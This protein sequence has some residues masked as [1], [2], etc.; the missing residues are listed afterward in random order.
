MVGTLV[1]GSAATRAGAGIAHAVAATLAGALTGLAVGSVGGLLVL[2]GPDRLLLLAL[3]TTCYGAMELGLVRLP[4]PRSGRQVPAAWRYRYPPVVTAA[5]YGALLGPG[6]GTRVAN[7]GYVVVLAGAAL[8]GD[9]ATGAAVLGTYGAARGLSAVILANAGTEGSLG[10]V[11]W[12]LDRG[13]LWRALSTTLTFAVLGA[14]VAAA[15]G[16]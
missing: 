6:V 10:P 16:A 4:L 7:A 2:A 8:L 5:L 13:P 15:V 1:R 11:L 12:G 3:V 9:A 14:A